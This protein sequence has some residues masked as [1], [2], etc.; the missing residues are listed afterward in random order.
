MDPELP[1]Y[2]TKNREL[3]AVG[4]ETRQEDTIPRP[5][6]VTDATREDKPD[7]LRA[8]ARAKPVV[9]LGLLLG[10]SWPLCWLVPHGL[11]SPLGIGA[12]LFRPRTRPQ[13]PPRKPLPNVPVNPTPTI[14]PTP[15]ITATPQGL[16]PLSPERTEGPAPGG[17]PRPMPTLAPTPALPPSLC[18]V[19]VMQRLDAGEITKEEAARLLGDCSQ[20]Q[21]P[22][23]ATT[24]PTSTVPATTFPGQQRLPNPA[25]KSVQRRNA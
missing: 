24:L 7:R 20:Q 3:R 13:R 18:P 21:A 4:K 23:A 22:A 10:L 1:D 6:P 2:A 9:W 15:G 8:S 17:T 25:E 11:R 12:V 19:M 14:T 5:V 16:A